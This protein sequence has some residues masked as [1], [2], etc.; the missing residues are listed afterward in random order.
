M[1]NEKLSH[2][3][4]QVSDRHIQEAATA[5][6]KKNPLPWIGAIA[7]VLAVALLL[8]HLGAPAAI[9]AN[10]VSLAAPCRALQRPELDAY[11]DDDAWYTDLQTWRAESDARLLVADAALAQMQ[12]FLA[13]SCHK[14]L[15][16]SDGNL[17][18][19]PI[20]TY[21]GLAMAAELTAG[22]TRQQLLT[23]LGASDT[24]SLRKQISAVWEQ[25]YHDD[26]KEICT[27]ANSLWLDDTVPFRQEVMDTLAYS[28]Y[29]S[30]Y[31]QDLESDQAPRDI[32]AW[33]DE[34]TGSLLKDYTSRIQLPEDPLLVLYSTIYFQSKWSYSD[35]F[36]ES[37]NT[38]GLF[39]APGGDREVT[40]MN[41]RE[42]NT[43]Y[44][45]G[46]GYS[47]IHLYLQ[48]GSRMWFILPDADSSLE[49]VLASG[50]YLQTVAGGGN[51]EYLKVNLSIPKFDISAQANLAEGL[52]ELGVTLLLD[53]QQADFSASLEGP[54]YITAVSQAVRVAID[55]EGVTAA[56]YVELP[57]AGA[58]PPPEKIVD[59]ILDRPFLF[60]I[61]D[62]SGLPLFAGTVN[63]P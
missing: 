7:A 56:A 42:K 15:S 13:S 57:A 30:V 6:K 60:V 23:L 16:G 52:K 31:R 45:W 34:N 63:Q 39:H 33:L 32:A 21:I 47:A 8:P 35:E 18:Y 43:N 5:K 49:Q 28:Y 48:N 51:S 2:A 41:A 25:V 10:A 22:Q 4:D 26:G 44:Y 38:Q 62:T 14:F 17:L 11:D 54:A 29:A 53:P 1:K 37:R 50:E 19:A 59:F 55:E 24:E 9:Q 27:L 46:E 36:N 58:A 3:L 20:N 12:P 40:Y 61:A